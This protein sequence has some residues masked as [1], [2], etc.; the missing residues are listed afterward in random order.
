MTPLATARVISRLIS[1]FIASSSPGLGETT[2]KVVVAVGCRG[3]AARAPSPSSAPT[4]AAPTQILHVRSAA[5]RS[6]RPVT[7][8]GRGVPVRSGSPSSSTRQMGPLIAAPCDPAV[9]S[10]RGL[11]TPWRRG[12]R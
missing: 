9:V 8:S 2:S 6:A 5:S 1:V 10:H 3:T 12:A 7:T 4:T 11:P